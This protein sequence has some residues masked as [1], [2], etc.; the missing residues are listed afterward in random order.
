MPDLKIS[1][2]Q[3]FISTPITKKTGMPKEI[4]RIRTI[5]ETIDRTAE[6][7]GALTTNA[8]RAEKWEGNEKPEL[9]VPR[10]LKWCRECDG[11]VVIPEDSEGVRIEEGWLSILRKPILRLYENAVVHLSALEANLDQL[12]PVFDR[13]FNSMKDVEAH[14][15]DFIDFLEHGLQMR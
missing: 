7:R 11:A 4:A 6:N 2:L 10:D 12:T 9:F 3:L 13:V 8:F 14:V 15:S 1:Q 5:V